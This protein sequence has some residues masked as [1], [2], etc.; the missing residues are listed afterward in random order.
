MRQPPTIDCHIG[1]CSRV[2]SEQH[3]AFASQAFSGVARAVAALCMDAVGA[4][5]AVDSG[6]SL[7]RRHQLPAPAAAD[8]EWPWHFKVYVMGAFRV[9]KG[10]APLR[11]SR[12]IQKKTL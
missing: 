11:F 9:L 6:R 7:P 8:G 12:R 3:P 1:S 2:E 4:A 5:F 10:D